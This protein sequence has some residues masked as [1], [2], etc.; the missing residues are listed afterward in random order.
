MMSLLVSSFRTLEGPDAGFEAP[1]PI[2]SARS[3]I[4]ILIV[5]MKIIVIVG[6]LIR[7]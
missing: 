7:H 2:H 1:L 6:M 5:V 3:I 4:M